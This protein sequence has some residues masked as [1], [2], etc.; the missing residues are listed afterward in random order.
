M[1]GRGWKPWT[2]EAVP[3]DQMQEYLQDQVVQVHASASAADAQV[4]SPSNGMVQELLDRGH[5]RS[6]RHRIGGVWQQVGGQTD[7]AWTNITV[8]GLIS[9]MVAGSDGARY[10]V[11]GGVCYFQAHITRGTAWGAATTMWTFPAGARP[12]Y[13][14]WFTPPTGGELKV[15]ASG[16][17]TLSVSATI[18]VASGSFPI[19]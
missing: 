5:R 3:V 10:R 7:D 19:D 12:P 1:P 18:M 2:A 13:V 9:G 6:L 15:N 4:P 8:N 16:V 14:H 17:V 11:V